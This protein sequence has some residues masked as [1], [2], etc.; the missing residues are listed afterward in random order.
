M[1]PDAFRQ[2]LA[3]LNQTQ[4]GFARAIGVDPRTVRRWALGEAAVPRAIA[5]L[6]EALL[7]IQLHDGE[8][9]MRAIMSA[10]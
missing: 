4:Q 5:V 6:L 1:D 7:I 3:L 2:R 9:R 8:E 10:P